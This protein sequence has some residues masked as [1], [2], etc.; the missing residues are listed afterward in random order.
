MKKILMILLMACSSAHA[1]DF[2]IQA[3]G[4]SVHSRGTDWCQQNPG[5]GLR[6]NISQEVSVQGGAYRNSECEKVSAYLM[7]NYQPFQYGDFTAGVFAGVIT[8]YKRN[9]NGLPAAG[10]ILEYAL[11]ER[12]KI[13]TRFIPKIPATTAAILSFEIGVSL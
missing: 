1:G 5:L 3:T 10:L 8:G 7:A 11:T 12:V 2:A 4:L 13:A 9:Y 6:Y